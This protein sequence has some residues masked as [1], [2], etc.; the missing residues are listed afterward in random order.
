M[1]NEFEKLSRSKT[2]FNCLLYENVCIRDDFTK[3]SI[4]FENE[5]LIYLY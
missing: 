4:C 2:N 3:S 5:W 1:A